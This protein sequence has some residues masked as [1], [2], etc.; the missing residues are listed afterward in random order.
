M[1]PRTKNDEARLSDAKW[2]LQLAQ[3]DHN[4]CDERKFT[5]MI[6][7]IEGTKPTNEGSS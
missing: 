7:A 3:L 1:K 5:A 4:F 6:E 2:E